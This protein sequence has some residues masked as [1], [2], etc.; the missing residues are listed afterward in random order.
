MAQT[1][2]PRAYV[3]T[4]KSANAITFSWT[5]FDGGLDFNGT[6]PITGATGT[7]SV[8]VVSYYHSFGFFGRSANATAFLPYG[9]GTFQ[10]NVLGTQ[11]QVYRSGLLDL[12]LRFS[13]NLMG[14]PAMATPQFMKWKQKTL[15]GA[16][17]TVV[18]PTGQYDPTQLINWGINRWALK[19]ELGYSRRWGNWVL[20]GYGGSGS[21]QRTTLSFLYPIPSRRPKVP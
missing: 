3:I 10:G 12:T 8:P 15:L 6:I 21:I 17:L 2:A 11:R 16:S 7:Y 14:G 1:L 9:V 18:A 13:V 20:D 4:P 5:F 19:P